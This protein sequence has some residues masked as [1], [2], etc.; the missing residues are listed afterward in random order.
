VE[1]SILDIFHE[2]KLSGSIVTLVYDTYSSAW[3]LPLLLL[4]RAIKNGYFGV[5]S[6]Y[7]IP[8]QNL[9]KKSTSVGLDMENALKRGDVAI[10]DL[11]GTRYGSKLEMPNVF[12]LDKVEPE[13]LNP[14]ISHIYETALKE[15]LSKRPAFRLIYTLDGAAL[16]LGEENTLKLLNRTI[17]TRSIQLPDSVLVIP[18]NRDVVSEKFVA[19]TVS[20]GDY[21]LVARSEFRGGRH[22]EY[23]Y[24]ISAPHEDFEPTTYSFRV[25]KSKGI[26]KL[27]IEKISP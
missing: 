3:K 5:V 16:M 1:T 15:V 12:Y 10:I 9:M 14:K 25:T 20:V 27:K 23:L 4:C 11:F 17:A 26:E 2:D 19:W 13:T 21:V 18:V 7:N 22:I 8:V 24:L 6:N